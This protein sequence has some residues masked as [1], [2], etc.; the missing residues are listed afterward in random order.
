MIE[1]AVK[2][3]KLYVDCL[4]V[5]SKTCLIHSPRSSSEECKVLGDFNN[6]YDKGNPTKDRSNHTV[7]RNKFN[8]QQENIA[9]VNNAMDE[10]LL[11]KTP[12]VSA[13]KEVPEFLESDYDK[14]NISR[15]KR[16]VLNRLKKKLNDI[17]RHLNANKKVQMGLKIKTI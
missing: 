16:R 12:K 13:A 3:I 15:L 10:I 5:K 17:S 11:H 8:K 4:M 1:S 7:P 2:R 14:K 9:I 6:K